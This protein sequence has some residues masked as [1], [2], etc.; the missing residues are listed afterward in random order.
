MSSDR[1]LLVVVSGPSGVGKT[2]LTTA[3]VSSLPGVKYSVSYTTRPRRA[4]EVEGRDYFFIGDEEFDR[5]CRD[6]EF[7]EWAEVYGFRYGRSR[8]QMEQELASGTDLILSIDVQG[9]RTLRRLLPEAVMI[10]LLPPSRAALRER[11]GARRTDPPG[12]IERRLEIAAQEVHQYPE[13]DY[14]IVN[15]H[16][17][18]ARRLLEAIILAE[19]HRR[20]RM[21]P[22]ARSI[23]LTFTS[24]DEPTDAGGHHDAW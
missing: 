17:D 12:E 3:L 5:M 2:T 16:L 7:I 23:L 19:R 6:G 9:A 21:E 13:F 1:G 4:D 10:F 11:L 18:E 15:D 8:R 24:A 20:T 14:L 22:R